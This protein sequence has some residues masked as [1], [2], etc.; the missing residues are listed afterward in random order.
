M[1]TVLRIYTPISV[2]EE[3]EKGFERIH[4]NQQK[5]YTVAIVL[6]IILNV[7]L[8]TNSKPILQLIEEGLR[9]FM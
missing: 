8:G 1:K 6:F 4:W 5:I 7:L 3:K 9:N 2:E